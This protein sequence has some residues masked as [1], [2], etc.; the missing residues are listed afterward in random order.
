MNAAWR[1]LR[2]TFFK[3]HRDHLGASDITE[4]EDNQGMIHH[5]REELERICNFYYS[6][7]YSESSQKGPVLEARGVTLNYL[8][9][10]LTTDIKN[11]LKSLIQLLELEAALNQIAPGKAPSKDG[12]IVEFFKTYWFSVMTT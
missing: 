5:D 12:M 9:D 11:S 8:S 10:H 4:L 2:K 7:L 1:L 6:S 3:A